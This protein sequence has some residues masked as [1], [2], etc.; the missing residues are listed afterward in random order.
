TVLHNLDGIIDLVAESN[1]TSFANGITNEQ[2]DQLKGIQFPIK[3][4]D[5]TGKQVFG[6]QGQYVSI[7]EL[8][9]WLGGSMPLNSS[10]AYIDHAELKL[11]NPLKSYSPLSFGTISTVAPGQ[12]AYL[13]GAPRKTTDRQ[14]IGK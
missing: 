8:S 7:S 4:F 3:L 9:P 13:V 5:S 1:G 10:I 2:I 12:T 14:K 11:S 6:E